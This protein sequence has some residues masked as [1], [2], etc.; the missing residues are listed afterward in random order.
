MT[1]PPLLILSGDKQA[2][3]T[4]L[5][6]RIAAMARKNGVD[7]GGVISPA[8]LCR[9]RK[10]GIAAL[11][12]KTRNWRQIAVLRGEGR[13]G[14]ETGQWSFFPERLQWAN[15]VLRAATPCTLL[16]VDELGPLELERGEGWTAGIEW[17]DEKHYCAAVAVVRPALIPAAL[18]RWPHAFI[19]LAG[20]GAR[21]KPAAEALFRQLGIY[22]SK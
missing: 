21:G 11:D 12:V 19:R 5:C 13:T 8:L 18:Q 2:G 4:T 9:G 1:E 20:P 3:K 7:T 15:Q 14:L 17:L 16:F 6:T 10:T 22:G